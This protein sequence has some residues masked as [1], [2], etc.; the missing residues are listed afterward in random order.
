MKKNWKKYESAILF[1][2]VV[3]YSSLFNGTVT[4]QISKQSCGI[5]GDAAV[6]AP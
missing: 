4:L 3:V 1:W 5:A 2:S 6:V